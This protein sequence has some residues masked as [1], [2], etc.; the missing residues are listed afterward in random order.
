M[1]VMV[2]HILLECINLWDTCEKYFTISSIRELFE[3]IEN[4]TI[5][6]V[7]KETHFYQ[8]MW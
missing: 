1:P 4:F 7:L 8:K 6:Y 5:I 2:K 3:S